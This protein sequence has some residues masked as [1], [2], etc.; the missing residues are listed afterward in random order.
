MCSWGYFSPPSEV[1]SINNPPVAHLFSAIYSCWLERHIYNWWVWG[2]S[3]PF[4]VLEGLPAD[5][6][7]IFLS[8]VCVGGNLRATKQLTQKWHLDRGFKHFYFHPY[9]GKISN[10]TN[11][12][13]MGWNHQLGM[14][15]RFE[16][17]PNLPQFFWERPCY[18]GCFFKTRIL[19]IGR[20]CWCST[21]STHC[22]SPLSRIY[23]HSIV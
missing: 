20:W 23:Q 6:K 7:G 2:P 1:N 4:L 8:C 3:P 10:L 19:E 11:I 15:N 13:Q 16:S 18:I 21:M 5:L 12:F 9:L 14:D 17:L 22:E